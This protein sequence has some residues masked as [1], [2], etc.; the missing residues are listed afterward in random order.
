MKIECEVSGC[1]TM[2]TISRWK[3]FKRKLSS[4]RHGYDFYA[5][6]LCPEHMERAT[7][8]GISDND[9]MTNPDLEK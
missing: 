8:G 7:S 4:L 2:V 5:P 3:Q 6:I 9:P 1:Y